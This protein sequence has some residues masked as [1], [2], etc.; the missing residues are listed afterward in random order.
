LGKGESEVGM[1]KII[2]EIHV[3][4]GHCDPA[5]IIFNPNYFVW[6]DAAM[7]RLVRTAHPQ[8]HA[9]PDQP[10]FGGLPLVAN[11]GE[12]PASA[13]FGDVMELASEIVRMGKSSLTFQHQFSVQA[14]TVAIIEETRV[15]TVRHQDNPE[16]LAAAPIP[17]EVRSTLSQDRCVRF[18]IATEP[19]NR[20]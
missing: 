17:D 14:T 5:R 13:R 4:W 7:E 15:W 6:A 12:F 1:F 20:A 18:S 11:S 10:D 9:S 3:E 16:Q 2:Q 19:Q 8:L